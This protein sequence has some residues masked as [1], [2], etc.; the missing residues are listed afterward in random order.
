MQVTHERAPNG[1]AHINDVIDQV[2]LEDIG[3]VYKAIA[4][5][6]IDRVNAK[7][8]DTAGTAERLGLRSPKAWTI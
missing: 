7:A 1:F 4:G 2:E 6:E 3:K 8:K 5:F